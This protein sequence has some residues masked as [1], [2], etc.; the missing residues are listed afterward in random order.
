MV[1]R[2]NQKERRGAS[3]F[4]REVTLSGAWSLANE[5]SVPGC[6]S[7]RAPRPAWPPGQTDA[8]DQ[9]ECCCFAATIQDFCFL[10]P[11]LSTAPAIRP[12]PKNP[13][14]MSAAGCFT[15]CGSKGWKLKSTFPLL[16]RLVITRSA[17]ITTANT[18]LI[19]FICFLWRPCFG[20]ATPRRE[21]APFLPPERFLG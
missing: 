17:T 20:W 1:P 13:K 4:L 15:A 8:R 12:T 21:K 3:D 9:R 10:L 7:C 6:K 5:T 11:R 16:F 2:R 19:M 14:Y 18:N